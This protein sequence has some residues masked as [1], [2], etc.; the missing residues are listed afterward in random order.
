M[1]I[2]ISGFKLFA[3]QPNRSASKAQSNGALALPMAEL[4]NS[5][6]RLRPG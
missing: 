5:R 3:P 4:I 2:P 1:M 6:D